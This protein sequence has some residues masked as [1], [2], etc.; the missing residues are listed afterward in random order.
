MRRNSEK[1][2]VNEQKLRKIAQISVKFTKKVF[3]KAWKFK[4]E[5][6]KISEK[7]L[8]TKRNTLVFQNLN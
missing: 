1:S 4:L 3:K 6:K 2:S 8:K 5:M 7:L